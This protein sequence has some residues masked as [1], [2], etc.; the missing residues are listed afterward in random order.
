MSFAPA[1]WAWRH[2]RATGAEGRCIGR[3]DLPVDR[4]R[5]KRLARRIQRAARRAGLARVVFTSPLQRCAAVGRQ[6]RAW[7]WQHRIE[8]ALLEMDF[9]A[10]EGRAWSAIPR[11]EV[12]AWCTDFSH[13][14]PGGGEPLHTL[15]ERVAAWRPETPAIVVAH[16]GWMLAR[17]WLAAGESGLPTA[18]SWPAPPAH[19][20]LWRLQ[21]GER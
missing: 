16:A 13:H 17:C 4:R 15:F 2:P 5:A 8:P 6:L 20:A 18:A 9:G 12:D 21:R 10:W 19:G 1:V 11:A 3:T 7:G 14:A